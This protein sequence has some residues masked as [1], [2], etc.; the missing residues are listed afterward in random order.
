MKKSLISDNITKHDLFQELNSSETIQ[1]NNSTVTWSIKNQ[2]F[3]RVMDEISNFQNCSHKICQNWLEAH[4]NEN[5]SRENIKQYKRIIMILEEIN[6]LTE[7]AKII[8]Q[9]QHLEKN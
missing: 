2:N 4:K 5:L 1:S 7:R 3:E 6:M 8:I 9:Y